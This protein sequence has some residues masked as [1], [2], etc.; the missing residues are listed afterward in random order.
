MS[1]SSLAEK[2]IPASHFSNG[3][4]GRKIERICLHHMAG[5]L[6]CEQ[7]G[8]IFQGN[9]KAS[10]HYGIGNDGRIAQYVDEAN[11]AW[12]NS[13]WDSNCKSV[14]IE[15]SNS[16]VGGN[17]AISDTTLNSLIKFIFKF[18]PFGF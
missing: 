14:T 15:N 1:N 3:R 18:Y 4:D 16:E 7:C 6:S 11:T 2:F 8:R 13:N 12:A 5:V 17:W 9:R 10:T